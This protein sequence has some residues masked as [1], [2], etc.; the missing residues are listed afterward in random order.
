MAKKIKSK[1]LKELKE[2]RKKLHKIEQSQPVF[3]QVKG[4]LA[5]VFDAIESL[6]YG[7]IIT[8]INDTVTFENKSFMSLF[9]YSNGEDLLGK[10]AADLFVSNNICKLADIDSA[11]DSQNTNEGEFLL[12]Q[13]NGNCIY[14]D[15]GSSPVLNS[16]GQQIGRTISFKDISKQKTIQREKEQIAAELEREKNIVTKKNKELVRLYSEVHEYVGII[17]HDLRNPLGTIIGFSDVLLDEEYK[18]NNDESKRCIEAINDNARYML[19]LTNDILDLT[20]IELGK[21]KLNITCNDYLVCLNN[22]LILN[23][24]HADSK[25]IKI[26][27]VQHN[28]TVP[29]FYYDLKKIEQVLNNLINNAIKYSQSNTTISVEV[30]VKENKVY[31][32][33]SDQGQGILEEDMALLFK[34]FSKTKTQPTGNERSSGLGLFITRKIIK[35]HKGEITVSSKVGQGSTFNFYI[36]YL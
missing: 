26:D 18:L 31:T 19:G 6:A 16:N 3:E 29:V 23:R 34:P 1:L 13:K 2:L 33:I 21:M 20:K 12:Y 8:D 7:I 32:T 17:S 11:I 9:E 35:A 27:F 5:I 28:M 30:N 15:V 10:S 4:S 22:C 25:D 36:P 24:L 14:M